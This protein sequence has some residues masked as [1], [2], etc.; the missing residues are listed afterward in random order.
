[1]CCRAG[2]WCPSDESSFAEPQRGWVEWLG[3][4][5]FVYSTQTAVDDEIMIDVHNF[6]N[7]EG[8]WREVRMSVLSVW[9]LWLTCAVGKILKS[10]G[11]HRTTC[12]I[13]VVRFGL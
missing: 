9:F 11:R 10:L 12:S 7:G 2:R 1:M 5:F 3:A 13:Q 4:Q 8:V 6:A